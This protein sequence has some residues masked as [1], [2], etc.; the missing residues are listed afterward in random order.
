M[1]QVDA[2]DAAVVQQ[3]LLAARRIVC[4][5]IGREGLALKAFAMRLF[6]IGF[7]VH[8]PSTCCIDQFSVPL[9]RRHKG[10][11]FWHRANFRLCL[12]DF[13]QSS[14]AK[15]IYKF[16]SIAARKQSLHQRSQLSN[17]VVSMQASPAF[18]MTTPP[19][20]PGDCLS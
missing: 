12:R 2:A 19:V 6:H 3:R 9:R 11:G 7:Q 5:G 1:Q 10:H 16:C 14:H 4:F 8:A 17:L 15:D 20:G 13:D 18:E